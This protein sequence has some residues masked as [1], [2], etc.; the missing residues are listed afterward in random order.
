[1]SKGIVG[2]EVEHTLLDGS[3]CSELTIDGR[4]IGRVL[5]S[6]SVHIGVV[7]AR[8]G[9]LE[10][11]TITAECKAETGWGLPRYSEIREKYVSKQLVPVSFA[12]GFGDYKGSARI[13]GYVHTIEHSAQ[14]I[15]IT[16]SGV[17]PITPPDPL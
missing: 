14:R 7:D 15:T 2:A 11:W 5:L 9:A 4:D 8:D 10:T 13:I 12:T 6:A 16:L 3:A 1:M 17:G